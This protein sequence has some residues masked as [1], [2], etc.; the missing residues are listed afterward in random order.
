M[1]D[2]IFIASWVRHG[3]VDVTS[4]LAMSLTKPFQ[5]WAAILTVTLAMLVHPEVQR[6]AQDELDRVVGLARLPAFS[7]RD[8]LPYLDCVIQECKR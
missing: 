2:E 6:K 3:S 4:L 5:T 1:T 7:D 8:S